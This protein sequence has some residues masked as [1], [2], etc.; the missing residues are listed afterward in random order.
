MNHLQYKRFLS[1]MESEYVDVLCSTEDSCSS[2]G[3]M[4][5]GAFY[6]KSEIELFLKVKGGLSLGFMITT[7]CATLRYVLTSL[8]T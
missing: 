1:D 6:L 2:R 4:P 3:C 7:R 5:K 8:S